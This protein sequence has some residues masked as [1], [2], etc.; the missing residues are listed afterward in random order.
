MEKTRIL[1]NSGF[2]YFEIIEIKAPDQ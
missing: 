1:T 2:Y